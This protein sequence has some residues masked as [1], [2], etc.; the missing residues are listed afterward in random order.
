MKRILI[1]VDMQ[2]DFVTGALRNEEAIKIVPSVVKRVERA[3]A[4]G[5][6][7]IFTRDTHYAD[8][9]DTEEGKNLPVPH[10]IKDTE[11]WEIIPQLKGFSENAETYDKPVFGSLKLGEDLSRI[12]DKDVTI[13]LIGLCTDICVISNAVIARA[14]CPDA[15]IAVDAS[16]CAGVTPESHKTALEAMKVFQV[17][18]INEV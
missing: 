2:N 18:I 5:E 14:A 7:I 3:E 4:A 9:M 15:H 1:V 16:C 12:P 8:Y 6:R 10:C 13:E 11:G 17:E